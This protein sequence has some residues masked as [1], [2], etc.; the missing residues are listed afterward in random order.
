MAGV[1][2]SGVVLYSELRVDL[3][4]HFSH[5]VLRWRVLVYLPCCMCLRV[6]LKGHWR[7]EPSSRLRRLI[8]Y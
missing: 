3:R 8:Q 7:Y 2:I 5:L 4:W 1:R 6:Q